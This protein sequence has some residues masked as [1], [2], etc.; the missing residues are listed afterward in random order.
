[1]G[2]QRRR[3][4]TVEEFFEWQRG[5]DRNYELVDGVPILHR[6]DRSGSPGDLCA[7]SG[8]LRNL[9]SR[10]WGG[11]IDSVEESGL[12]IL[13]SEGVRFQIASP[14]P[15]DF[16]TFAATA[17]EAFAGKSVVVLIDTEEPRA[18]AWRSGPQGRISSE[19]RGE[20]AVLV[21]PEINLSLSMA[22]LYAGMTLPIT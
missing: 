15:L 12:V 17:R 4:M 19:V 11:A 21:I 20:D 10:D 14:W 8:N 1:M 7:I 3:K 5:Q 2:E 22:D 13:P 9:L 6:R 16:E 18:T